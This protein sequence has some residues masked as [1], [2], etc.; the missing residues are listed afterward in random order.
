MAPGLEMNAATAGDRC[1]ATASE[2]A[3]VIPGPP[4]AEPGIQTR[5]FK[6]WIPGSRKR[7]PRNDV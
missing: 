4:K 5:S 6:D 2:T 1:S 3:F 7:A